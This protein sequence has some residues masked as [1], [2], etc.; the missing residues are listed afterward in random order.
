VR[1]APDTLAVAAAATIVERLARALR[2]Q[3]LAVFTPSAGRTP[4]ACYARLRS[5]HRDALDWERVVCVQMDEYAGLAPNHPESL[6]MALETDLVQPLGIGTFLRLSGSADADAERHEAALAALGGLDVVLHGIGRNGHIAFNEPG[7]A[8]RHRSGLVA[9]AP[10]TRADNA[11]A[12]TTGIT[13]GIDV[14]AAARLSVVMAIGAHKRDAVAK[15][16]HEPPGP[17]NPAGYLRHAAEVH[18]LLDPAAG[19]AA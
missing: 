17:Q 6:A 18:V 5:H 14:L 11:V 16:L 1:A 10:T 13:L 7:V 9:I 2:T 3:P 8:A 4:T 12:A 15:L 19:S